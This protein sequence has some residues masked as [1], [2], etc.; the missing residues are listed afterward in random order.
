MGTRAEDGA[1]IATARRAVA[2]RFREA[3]LDTPDLDARLIVGQA[4]GLDLGG[5]VREGERLLDPCVL[6]GIE[7]LAVRRLAGEPVARI[8]GFKEFWGLSFAVTP[9]VLVPRPETETVVEAAVARLEAT[10]A[11]ERPLRIADLGTGSGVILV[12]LLHEFSHAFG[13]GTDCSVAAA[14]TARE[15]AQRL[16]A[17]SRA[18]FLA[19]DLGAALHGGFDLVVA[20][21]PYVA[22][23]E[24]AMLAREVRDFDPR[25]ALDGGADGLAAHRAILADAGRLLAQ[26]AVL[27]LEV[28]AGQSEAVSELAAAAGLTGVVA[29]PDLAGIPRVVSARQP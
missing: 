15:N 17:A 6:A 2:R 29:T 23:A 3:G 18:A 10:G 7:A 9:A 13:I 1:R 4:L 26:G 8:I 25:A 24:I 21:P 27:V 16:G 28:G 19:C 22:T 5:L 20:N 12:A 14:V 11:R